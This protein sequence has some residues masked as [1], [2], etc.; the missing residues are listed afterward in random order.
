MFATQAESKRVNLVSEYFKKAYDID[1]K[2]VY[3]NALAP[4][5]ILITFGVIPFNLGAVGGVFAQAKASTA[6]INIAEQ[7]YFSSDLCSTSRCLIGAAYKNAMP[8]PDFLILTSG[9]CDVDSHL[10]HTLSEI[11]GKKW[12]LLDIPMYYDNGEEAIDYLEA[13]IV[14]MIGTME[15]ELQV[16]FDLNKLKNVISNTNKTL[17]FVQKIN[18]FAKK[19]P[20]ALS[21][22]ETIDIVSSLHLLGS[23][24][25][26]E[27]YKEKYHEL[28]HKMQSLK[29]QTH[30][31]PRVF[32]HWLRPYF[33]NEIFEHL[34]NNCKLDIISEY[35]VMGINFYGWQPFNSEKPFRVMAKRMLRAAENYSITNQRFIR[36]IPSKLKEYSIDGVISFSP[37]G[38]R[39]LVSLNYMLRDIFN[40]NRIPFLEIDCDCIDNRDY[41]FAQI[42]TRLDAFSELLYGRVVE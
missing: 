16:S 13:Q 17:F 35:D 39:H 38:C 27:I 32:W 2:V 33:T 29:F 3:V 11:Y 12:Y 28:F 40:T 19:I 41:S 18:S 36:Q 34:I 1:R 24:E 9:P 42:Q 8:T 5:E 15:K 37:R 4:S 7:H 22:V 20:S 21:V 23:E 30:R 6:L 31:K 10:I 25:L 26:A 14:D